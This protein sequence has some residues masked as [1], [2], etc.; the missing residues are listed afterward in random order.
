MV[1]ESDPE[2]VAVVVT[3]DAPVSA[4]D[5]RDSFQELADR[6]AAVAGPREEDTRVHVVCHTC[7]FEGLAPS[8]QA[9]KDAV[10]AHERKHPDHDLSALVVET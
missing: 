10:E 2:T 6:M 4:E 9:G 7:T 1:F 8:E 5:L 3:F